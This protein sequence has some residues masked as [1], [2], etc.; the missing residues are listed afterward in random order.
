VDGLDTAASEMNS[1]EV[2]ASD[3]ISIAPM[4]VPE[5]GWVAA[6][7]VKVAVKTQ[8]APGTIAEQVEVKAKSDGA[9]R[10]RIRMVALPVLS[11]VTVWGELA[12][13]TIVF[14]KVSEFAEAVRAA[15]GP[16]FEGEAAAIGVELPVRSMRSGWS[17]R[18]S[19]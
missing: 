7:G 14:A 5:P 13:P 18:R 15:R 17:W 12:V 16:V 10:L 1:S 3:E 2:L 8:L 9:C 19:R 6:C 11:S 4:R